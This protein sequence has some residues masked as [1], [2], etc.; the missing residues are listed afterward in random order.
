MKNGFWKG[1]ILGVSISVLIVA[2]FTLGSG[3][4]NYRLTVREGADIAATD[5]GTPVPTET[6]VPETISAGNVLND[7]TVK[8]IENLLEIIENKYYKGVSEDDIRTSVYRGVMEGVGDPYTVYYTP[9]EYKD[10]RQTTSGI[11]GGVGS[12]I[13]KKS[14]SENAIFLNPFEGG[15][16][17][18][19]GILSE[20]IIYKVEDEIVL[21]M[22]TE[23]IANRVRGEVGTVVHITVY[24]ESVK[25]YL[26]FEIERAIVESPTVSEEVL[27]GNIGYIAVSS[28]DSVTE[29]QFKKAVDDMTSKDVK[30][31]IVDLRNNGGGVLSVC[32]NMADYILPQ[33]D[34]ITYTLDKYG[35]GVKYIS[36]DGHEVNIPIVILVNEY[37]ASASEV[38]TGALK[39]NG[40]AT[41]MGTTSFGKGIVQSIIP[42]PD[43]SAVKITT[44]TYYTPSGTCIHGIGITPDIT[45]EAEDTDNQKEEARKYLLGQ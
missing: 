35:E 43:G 37:S 19:A 33:Q 34:L 26:D 32:V 14:E 7:R 28:F 16:A 6:V 1:L 18:N 5:E 42:L 21:G 25:E 40:R 3:I 2:G 8:K 44:S 38:F 31:L 12:Y 23:E 17:Y 9:K 11:Y 29:S 24:R 36:K 27:E 39:D 22:S 41:V 10:M 13:S 30:G 45:V 15:P 20:D 4:A